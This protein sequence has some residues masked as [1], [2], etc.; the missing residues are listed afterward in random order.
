MTSLQKPDKAVDFLSI[1]YE[2][3][4]QQKYIGLLSTEGIFRLLQQDICANPGA[5]E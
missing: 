5:N 3:M 1:P 4:I 2:D